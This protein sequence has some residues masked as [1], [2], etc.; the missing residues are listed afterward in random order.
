MQDAHIRAPRANEPASR[1]SVS[2][3]GG[4]PGA[5]AADLQIVVIPYRTPMLTRAALKCAAQFA[6]GKNV[7]LRLIDVCVV[8]YGRDL[9]E[10][11]VNR[12]RRE[13]R[14]KILAQESPLHVS[15]EVFYARKWEH[16]FRRALSPASVVLLPIKISSWQSAEKRLAARLRKLGH[17][18]V[19][20][21]AELVELTTGSF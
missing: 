12:N 8:P 18:V 21:E 1:E 5:I 7:Q 2:D 6:E 11:P 17:E 3:A 20:V 14:L 9:A 4:R 10:A 19:W 16:G 15:A 13:R